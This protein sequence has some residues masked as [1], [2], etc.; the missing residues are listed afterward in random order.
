MVSRDRYQPFASTLQY[1]KKTAKNIGKH[2][3]SSKMKH[4]LYRKLADLEARGGEQGM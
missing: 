4:R 2:S 1:W 3:Q